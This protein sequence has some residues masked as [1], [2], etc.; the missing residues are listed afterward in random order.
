L[1]LGIITNNDE[2]VIKL[3]IKGKRKKNPEDRLSVSRVTP[4][5]RTQLTHT[6]GEQREDGST[7]LV[8][9]GNAEGSDLHG[10]GHNKG[11]LWGVG[12]SVFVMHETTGDDGLI[13]GDHLVAVATLEPF[14][15]LIALVVAVLHLEEVP[16]HA[17]LPHSSHQVPLLPPILGDLQIRK[18][19]TM[20]FG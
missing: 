15:V 17:V 19:S 18:W 10:R 6:A 2:T 3:K 5:H 14:L 7:E 11:C 9:A 8:P 1:N 12:D 13:L 20:D 4:Q 16:D